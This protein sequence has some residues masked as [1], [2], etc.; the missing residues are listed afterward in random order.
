MEELR[1]RNAIEKTGLEVCIC[2][3]LSVSVCLRVSPLRFSRRWALAQL[4]KKHLEL[5]VDDLH[6]WQKYLNFDPEVR[7]GGR[8]PGVATRLDRRAAAQAFNDFDS[9][10]AKLLA[11][12]DAKAGFAEQVDFLA[13][14]LEQENKAIAQLLKQKAKEQ[15]DGDKAAGDK[16]AKPKKK[17]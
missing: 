3:Y 13:E 14:K 4:L 8:P 1:A 6:R 5:H 15:T 16:K 9:D 17:V 10:S 12:L 2:L 7:A 11:T